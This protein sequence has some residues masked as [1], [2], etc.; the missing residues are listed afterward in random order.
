MMFDAAVC[1]VDDRLY[2]LMSV[3]VVTPDYI[4]YLFES[5]AVV[6]CYAM[7]MRAMRYKR[8]VRWRSRRH[9]ALR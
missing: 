2:A 3:I 5:G 7:I 6:V 9:A 1:H 8:G 4:D